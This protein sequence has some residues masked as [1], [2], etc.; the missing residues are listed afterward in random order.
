MG[1]V[2]QWLA[3]WDKFQS[4][5]LAGRDRKISD[6]CRKGYSYPMGENWAHRTRYEVYVTKT[7]GALVSYIGPLYGMSLYC[8]LN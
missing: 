4:L 3:D 1:Y 7:D 6:T 8:L 2:K 5:G